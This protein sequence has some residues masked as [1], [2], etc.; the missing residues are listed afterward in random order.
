MKVTLSA[1]IRE[2]LNSEA[3]RAQLR[4]LLINE[5]GAGEDKA[6]WKRGTQAIWDAVQELSPWCESND[7][8]WW[9]EI[10]CGLHGV[11]Q[12]MER[13]RG[14]VKRNGIATRNEITSPLP[15]EQQPPGTVLP[16]PT[17]SYWWWCF[18]DESQLWC[19]Q[20]VGDLELF[21]KEVESQWLGDGRWIECITVQL[22][23]PPG[24]GVK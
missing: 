23:R 13:L 21:R 19:P 8:E 9:D 15:Q 24:R 2:L 17:N 14:L 16:F 7:M 12:E 22:S 5:A 18:D 4:A 11:K 10:L 6:R 1:E 20:F 3:G